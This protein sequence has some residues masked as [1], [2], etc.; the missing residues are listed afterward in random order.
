MFH[1]VI[2]CWGSQKKSLLWNNDTKNKK[3]TALKCRLDDWLWKS[4]LPNCPDNCWR[5]D[6]YMHKKAEHIQIV[7]NFFHD[8]RTN[9]KKLYG[10]RERG[11]KK[12]FMQSLIYIHWR[13]LDNDTCR[14]CYC[15]ITFMLIDSKYVIG[16]AVIGKE[17]SVDLTELIAKLSL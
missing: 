14:H 4:P 9:D 2:S 16:F 10:R 8:T 3:L 12:H 6:N 17:I 7:R 1:A 15:I 13:K 11:T 5:D